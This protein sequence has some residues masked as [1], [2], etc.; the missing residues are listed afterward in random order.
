MKT[1]QGGFAGQPPTV[2]INK[3]ERLKYE[4]MWD[5]P[6]YRTVAPGEHYVEKFLERARPDPGD[7]LVDFGCG[8]GRAGVLLNARKLDVTMMDF[9][10]NCLDEWVARLTEKYHDHL[11]FVRHD[12]VKWP[13]PVPRAKYGYCCD[14]L[15]H[16]PPKDVNTVAWNVLRGARFV[17]LAISTKPDT[18]GN[19]AGEPLHLTVES[20][21]W[22][23]ARLE[24]LHAKILW[25]EDAG[26][27]AFFY[28]TA[29]ADA[30]DMYDAMIL[31]VEEDQIQ[32]QIVENL[33]LG[34]AEV[35]PHEKQPDKEVI[36]LAGGPSLNDF[37]D[38]IYE[39][40]KAGVPVVTVNGTYNWALNH[41]IRPAATVVLDGREFNK[42]FVDPPMAGVKYLLSS[43]CH[44]ELVK[45]LPKEQ[46]LLWHSG[47]TERVRKAIDEYV[48]ESQQRREWWPVYGGSTV[49][50]RAIILLR[51][52]GFAKLHIYGLDS[53]LVGDEHHAY[54]QPENDMTRVVDLTVGGRT[55]Q[56]HLWMWSQASEF[57]DQMR[58]MDDEME[59]AVYGDGLIA[60]ILKT[61][62]EMPIPP[63]AVP[64][65]YTIIDE[66]LPLTSETLEKPNGDVC[67]PAV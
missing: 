42:R 34:L 61:A 40:A 20:F 51:M 16:I 8:T 52:L 13:L 60:W 22:W 17:F 41:R 30:Q 55:F 67:I 31:N 58:A 65:V 25:S 43:Q 50:L 29:Y 47:A 23:K 19:L 35:C 64:Q 4:E 7:T 44:P 11:R 39:K 5:Q 28:V 1:A 63:D 10:G 62:A 32:R 18:M 21:D 37:A 9:A 45:S 33:R 15:E 53:C 3:T 48:Y 27:T 46:V 26:G 59:I 24:E 2:L 56:C 54:A 12:L 66:D 36:L 49:V 6:E 57:M 38:E 14:V